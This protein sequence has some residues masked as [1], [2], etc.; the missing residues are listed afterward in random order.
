MSADRRH[1]SEQELPKRRFD[2][3][4]AHH[5]S[6]TNRIDVDIS[7][8]TFKVNRPCL[9]ALRS[10]ELFR[11]ASVTN[12]PEQAIDIVVAAQQFGQN[13]VAMQQLGN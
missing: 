11:T 3:R 10:W 9:P 4:T 1:R 2:Q 12:C 5:R 8:I 13:F 6:N 7:P